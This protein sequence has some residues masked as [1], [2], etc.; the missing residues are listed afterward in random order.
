MVYNQNMTL[1]NA[2]D[3]L[4][5]E[6]TLRKILNAITFARTNQDQLRVVVDSGTI[7]T[8]T[9]ITN[10]VNSLVQAGNN[11]ASATTGGVYTTGGTIA[12]ASAAWNLQDAREIAR[13]ASE[14]QL[15]HTRNR[16]TIA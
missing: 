12:Y 13:E 8:V 4:G 14:V 7:G 1:R 15:I 3:D 2:F 5:L 10:G 16:W 9:G 11:S 6:S